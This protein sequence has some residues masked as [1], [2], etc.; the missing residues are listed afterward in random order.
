MP[1][2]L[3]IG[4]SPVVAST[5]DAPL[6]PLT[7]PD[8]DFECDDEHVGKQENEEREDVP[9]LTARAKGKRKARN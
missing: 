6:S 1:S 5:S 3:S 9:A 8:D 4:I 2:L 7:A